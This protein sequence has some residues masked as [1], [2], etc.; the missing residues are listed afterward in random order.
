MVLKTLRR[1]RQHWKTPT[2]ICGTPCAARFGMK[3]AKH[4][5]LIAWQRCGDLRRMVLKYT[6]SGP[7][8]HD[9]DYRR[10]LRRSARSACYLTSE[11]FYRYGHAEF[12]KFLN[13]ARGSLGEALDQI[14]DGH[15]NEYFT[16]AQHL[17][18]RRMCLRAM[19]ANLALKK[20][21]KHPA[22]G[23][24]TPPAPR[25]AQTHRRSKAP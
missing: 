3:V 6:R 14:D 21:W 8:A 24:G 23:T 5:D 7:A 9:Y 13:W 17:E 11:G 20:S 18:M 4:T 25:A 10:Q 2:N 19:K 15:E 16:D 12:A 22:P 1:Q